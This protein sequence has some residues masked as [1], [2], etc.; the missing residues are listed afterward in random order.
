MRWFIFPSTTKRRRKMKGVCVKKSSSHS[1]NHLNYVMSILP[2]ELMLLKGTD[3]TSP[4]VRNFTAIFPYSSECYFFY[5]TFMLS[6]SI[7]WKSSIIVFLPTKTKSFFYKNR[8]S[9]IKTGRENWKR[10]GKL[11]FTPYDKK[12]KLFYDF[13]LEVDWFGALTFQFNKKEKLS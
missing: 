5:F 13:W 3:L 10:N 1:Q 7:I 8:Y 12:A 11:S 6:R 4:I 9:L 2:H